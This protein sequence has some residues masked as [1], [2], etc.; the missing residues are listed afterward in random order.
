MINILEEINNRHWIYFIY[1]FGNQVWSFTTF[2]CATKYSKWRCPWECE[3][4]LGKAGFV[5]YC[6]VC[7]TVIVSVLDLP[8]VQPESFTLEDFELPY[9]TSYLPNR[10]TANSF[11]ELRIRMWLVI[12]INV[13][14]FHTVPLPFMFVYYLMIICVTYFFVFSFMI[15]LATFSFHADLWHMASVMLI[16]DDV[17]LIN[18]YLSQTALDIEISRLR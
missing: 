2:A 4:Y 6:H 13:S 5:L 14:W 7:H 12:V 8:Q 11:C 10:I 1:F 18:D 16:L 17:N 9:S 15:R 3:L